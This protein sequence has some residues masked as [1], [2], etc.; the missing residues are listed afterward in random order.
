MH[1][2]IS[3][4][5]CWIMATQGGQDRNRDRGCVGSLEVSG[6]EGDDRVD[7]ELCVVWCGVV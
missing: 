4:M 7:G 2:S 1:R 5:G 3:N 6:V